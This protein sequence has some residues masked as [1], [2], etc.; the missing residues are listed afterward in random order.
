MLSCWQHII[1]IYFHPLVGSIDELSR[2]ELI[3]P[4]SFVVSG[5]S[6]QNQIRQGCKRDK[7]AQQSICSKEWPS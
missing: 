7:V 6:A 4:T 1:S 5:L 2:S 3:F